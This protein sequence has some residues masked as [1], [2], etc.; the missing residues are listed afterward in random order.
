[1]DVEAFSLGH[2]AYSSFF[3][4]FSSFFFAFSAA[5]L[6]S[7]FVPSVFRGVS[8][9]RGLGGGRAEDELLRA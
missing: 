1:V 3:F 9:T 6:E 5:L 4:A 8:L 2:R 7:S